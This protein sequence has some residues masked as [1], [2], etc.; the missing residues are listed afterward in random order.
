VAASERFQVFIDT[1][2]LIYVTRESSLLHERA[3]T[4]LLNAVEAGPVRINQMVFA[5]IAGSFTSAAAVLAWLEDVQ[6]EFAASTP[7]SLFLASQ[8]FLAYRDRGGPSLS[9]LPDFFVGADAVLA[10]ETLLTNDAKRYRTYFP[11]LE[12][13]TP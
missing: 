9:I 11:D 5:E 4:A 1:S 13:I 12:L 3:V 8:A 2:I 10:G 6:I 7:E